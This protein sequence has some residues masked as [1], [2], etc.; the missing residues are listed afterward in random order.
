IKMVWN[1]IKRALL[2]DGEIGI[3]SFGKYKF[4]RNISGKIELIK[5]RS[6]DEF[7]LFIQSPA[8]SWYFFKFQRGIMY[9]VGSDPMYNKLIKDNVDKISKKDDYK[10][11]VANI[12][13]KNQ[14]LRGL[15]KK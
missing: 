13:A 6:G 5:R 2:S 12:S 10:L 11:R 15:T 3:N 4:E 7:T 1:P 8:G 9:T 14:F